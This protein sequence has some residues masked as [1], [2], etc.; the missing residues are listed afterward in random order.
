[1]NAALLACLF[2]LNRC[3]CRS[4]SHSGLGPARASASHS[5]GKICS[6]IRSGRRPHLGLVTDGTR[7]CVSNTGTVTIHAPEAA[8]SVAGPLLLTYKPPQAAMGSASAVISN[9]RR[10]SSS[11]GATV[12]GSDTVGADAHASLAR[13]S[14]VRSA[15]DAA[16]SCHDAEAA[17]SQAVLAPSI[18]TPGPASALQVDAAAATAGSSGADVPTVTGGDAAAFLTHLSSQIA[19]AAEQERRATE[20][21]LIAAAEAAVED[22]CGRYDV[23]DLTHKREQAA[24]ALHAA[25]QAF[26]RLNAAAHSAQLV[27]AEA[28]KAFCAA[29]KARRAAEDQAE[30]EAD[31]DDDDN[32]GAEE[33]MQAQ[34][35]RDNVDIANEEVNRT[36][37]AKAAAGSK[38]AALTAS[39][40]ALQTGLLALQSRANEAGEA[41][42]AAA[43]IEEKAEAEAKKLRSR[44]T[45][46]DAMLDER[47]RPAA[48]TAAAQFAEEAERLASELDEL[49][50]QNSGRRTASDP[51]K[52][53]AE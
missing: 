18:A 17:P 40:D 39:A 5:G 2:N 14:F 25:T 31:H 47:I 13:S 24:S 22:R 46:L 51:S 34:L 15:C 35:L 23:G 16:T 53:A 4:A 11:G 27:A 1:M 3:D 29:R 32:F 43:V 41:L 30:P 52:S 12:T 44:L 33:A 36:A 28:E 42:E 9:D 48:E 20:D 50:A 49:A 26:E 38:L 45:R 8:P 19:W 6:S 7:V 37:I 10:G 21:S